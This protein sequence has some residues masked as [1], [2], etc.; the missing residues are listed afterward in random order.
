MQTIEIYNN[1]LGAP[2][3]HFRNLSEG[4]S[5]SGSSSRNGSTISSCPRRSGRSSL[6]ESWYVTPPPCFTST[7]PIN[8]AT[9]P[10]EN[11]LIEHPSMSVYRFI[12]QSTQEIDDDDVV[13]L[14]FGGLDD[15]EHMNTID[16]TTVS[17]N[18]RL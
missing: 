13:L 4:S 16:E 14:S 6:E 3:R 18:V 7:G 11:L 1:P 12:T 15:L 2:S 8:M 9:S 5:V 17:N 10:L